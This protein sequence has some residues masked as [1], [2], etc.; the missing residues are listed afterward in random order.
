MQ[1]KIRIDDKVAINGSSA[2]IGLSQI[3]QFLKPEF[4]SIRWNIITSS[5]YEIDNHKTFI[6][7]LDEKVYDDPQGVE[8]SFSFLEDLTYKI[9]DIYDIVIVGYEEVFDLLRP[10][11]HPDIKFSDAEIIL[12]CFDSTCWYLYSSDSFFVEKVRE[13]FKNVEV[14]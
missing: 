9:Q 11:D 5:L 13:Y 12:E 14:E 3:L 1:Y 6:E 8:V 7:S 2:L 10:F 4:A